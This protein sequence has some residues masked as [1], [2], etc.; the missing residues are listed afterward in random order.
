MR[1]LQRFSKISD[2]HK[3]ANLQAP[4]H[5]LISLVDYTQIQYPQ[6]VEQLKW[7]Q[8]YF[9]IGLKRNVAYKFF[10]GQKEY[11]FD[12]G[13]MTFIAP[14]QVMS[15]T[16]NPNINR[17][18]RGWLLLIHPDFLWN[19]TLANRV[20]E[21]EFFDYSVNEALFLSEKEEHLMLDILKNIQREYQAN[22]DK[23][24][25]KI[26]ISQLELLLNY[27]ERFY[28]R[29][30]ITRKIVNHEILTQLELVLSDY[31]KEESLI[32]KGLPTVQFVADKLHLSPNY[33]SGVLKSLTGQSTQQH[34]HNKLIE[35]AKQ[36]LSTTR[37]S[38][39]EIAYNMGF[40][41]PASFTKLFKNKTE[42]SP[43][44]FRKSFN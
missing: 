34:I 21:Y 8:D 1:T 4:E 6:D 26:I 36:Q 13:L 17:K 32:E 2:Y 15:L 39:S 12:E 40:E 3:F 11:D 10:Y 42:M 22:I 24:S 28:E 25:Q 38:V 16:D 5:P 27:A 30:F 7:I 37:L 33:L 9:T 19:S 20:K 41:R 18:P 31:F 14:N 43:L 23:F 35:K 44:A 29:Q